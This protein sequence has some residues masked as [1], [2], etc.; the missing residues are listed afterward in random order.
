MKNEV[1][2][3]IL[4]RFSNKKGI[5]NPEKLARSK[6]Y[7]VNGFPKLSSHVK[8]GYLSNVVKKMSK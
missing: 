6:L 7:N 1:D 3:E 2:N 8:S 4:H 5:I